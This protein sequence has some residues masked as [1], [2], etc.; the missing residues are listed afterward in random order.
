MSGLTVS[1][2]FYVGATVDTTRGV[3]CFV[4]DRF[5][6]HLLVNVLISRWP[7]GVV[8]LGALDIIER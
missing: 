7:S 3:F 6:S 2:R 1:Y 5:P 4:V 8:K